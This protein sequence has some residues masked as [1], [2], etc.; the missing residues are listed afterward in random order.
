MVVKAKDVMTDSREDLQASD[1]ASCPLAV[2]SSVL[3]CCP[4]CGETKT[5]FIVDVGEYK[6][7]RKKV[8]C[9]MCDIMG[10][11]GLDEKGAIE[12][13]NRRTT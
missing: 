2:N 9:P 12:Q 1:G 3:L 7:P 5:L 13:W 4:W 10:P 8:L 6:R 11:E